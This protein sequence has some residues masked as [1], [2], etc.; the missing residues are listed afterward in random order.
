PKNMMLQR[1]QGHLPM[2][3]HANPRH[4]L[5]IGFGGGVTAGAVSIYPE[6]KLDIVE[7]EPAVTNVAEIFAPLNHDVIRRGRYH[8]VVNDGRNHLLIT[9]NRYDVITSDP[10]EPVV[11]GAAHLYTVETFQ[12]ARARLAPAG[13]MAQFLPLYELSRAD[14]MMILRTFVRVFPRTAV[15]FTG[16]DTVLLGLTDGAALRLET[17]AAKFETPEVR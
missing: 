4:V 1:M 16:T 5:N 11:A 14:L 12:W 9:T 8:L 6:T 3:F 2:L 10:F 13:I 15:F 17:V 7:I